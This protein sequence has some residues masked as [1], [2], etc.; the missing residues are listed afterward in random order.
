[1]HNTILPIKTG[2]SGIKLRVS[3]LDSSLKFYSGH[4]GFQ[5]FEKKSNYAMLSASGKSPYQVFLVESHGSDPVSSKTAGLY[6]AAIKVPNRQE[7]AMI[8][9]KL[10]QKEVRF[11]G[12]SDHL[13]SEALYLADPDGNGI[14]IYSDRPKEQWKW[15]NGQIRMETLPLDVESL[16]NE[17]RRMELNNVIHPDTIIGHIHLRVSD[18][19]KA[20]NFYSKI[21]GFNVTTREYPG[22]LFM[23]AGGYHHHIGTNIWSGQNIPPASEKSLG[24]DHFVIHIPDYNVLQAIKANLKDNE[25][26]TIDF[27]E[28]TN[29]DGIIYAK[30]FDGIKVYITSQN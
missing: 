30:D 29:A 6:H 1:L 12:F 13:V 2:I 17:V 26:G 27:K 9:K 22:A 5:V 4:L 16:L 23:S 10:S 8:L 11:H 15:S 3:N 14:E 20:E 7:L 25:F 21:L 28:D 24:L 19:Q 18:L